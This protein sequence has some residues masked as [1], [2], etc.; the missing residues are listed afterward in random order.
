[1]TFTRLGHLVLVWQALLQTKKQLA[2]EA[3]GWTEY[4]VLWTSQQPTKSQ[5]TKPP[6]KLTCNPGKINM[7][8]KLHLNELVRA[9]Q[10]CSSESALQSRSGDLAKFCS[11]CLA[12]LDHVPPVKTHYGSY[13][14][15]P[16]HL[17][18]DSLSIVNY[19][20]LSSVQKVTSLSE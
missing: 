14:P 13:S 17:P 2:V 4:T 3:A 15:S 9:C 18:I 12:V 7:Q 20:S 1:M 11:T 8:P 5:N 10:A 6:A 19:Y 16:K